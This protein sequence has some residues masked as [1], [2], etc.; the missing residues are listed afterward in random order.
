MAQIL[1]SEQFL[2]EACF[3][4]ILDVRTAK[5]FS[6]GHIEGAVN[7][8]FY[9]ADFKEEIQ[10]LPESTAIFLYCRSGHRSSMACKTLANAGYN[11]LFELEGGMLAWDRAGH[12]SVKGNQ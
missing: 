7:I 3:R 4:V 12:T 1:P 6:E 5:E 11:D 9:K 10:S 2:A 8:D